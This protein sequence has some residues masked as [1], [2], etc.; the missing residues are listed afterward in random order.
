MKI[1]LKSK[2]DA[3]DKDPL[4]VQVVLEEGGK[5]KKVTFSVNIGETIELPDEQAYEVLH[6]YKGLFELV[7]TGEGIKGGYQHRAASV[8]ANKAAAAQEG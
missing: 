7:Q 2:A 5:Q 3:S 1:K 4:I 6:K 8:Q